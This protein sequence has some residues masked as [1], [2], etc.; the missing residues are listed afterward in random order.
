[1][2]KT[3]LLLPAGN[4]EAFYAAV[5][6]GADAIYLGI[7]KFNARGRAGNFTHPQLVSIMEIA[8]KKKI[9]I[10]V[11][12]NTVIKNEELTELYSTLNILNAAQ[13]DALIVQ[14][15]GV[16]FLAKKYFPQ[17]RLHCST[18][19]GLHNSVGVN[20]AYK[21]GAVRAVLARELTLRELRSI[22]KNTQADLEVF[23][24]GALCYSFSGMCLFSSYLGGSGANR[25]LCTQPC[26]RIFKDNKEERLLFS[27]KDNEQIELVPELAKMGINSIKIE[28][29]MKAAEY[30][31]RVGKAYRKALDDAAQI[32]IAKRALQFDFA[33][34]KTAYFLGGSGR[35][36]FTTTANTGRLIGRIGDVTGESFIIK[37]DEELALGYRLRVVSA[38]GEQENLKISAI[39]KTAKGYQISAHGKIVRHHDEVYLAG[40]PEKKFVSRLPERKAPFEKRPPMRPFKSHDKPLRR[41]EL[42]LRIDSMAW[43]RKIR[44]E[45]FDR[46]ILALTKKEWA[47]FNYDAPFLQKNRPKFIFELPKFIPEGNIHEYLKLLQDASDKGFTQFSLSHLLQK[48]LLPKDARF[49]TNENV[50]AFNDA[51]ITFIKQDGA[52]NFSYPLESD[53][54]NLMNIHFKSGILPLY[55]TPPVFV[56]RMPINLKDT[57]FTDDRNR[58]FKR[59]IRDGVTYIYPDLPTAW[60]HYREKFEKA[61][62]RSFLIDFSGIAPSKHLPKRVLQHYNE[63]LAMSTATTFNMKMGLK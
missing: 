42:Y 40:I 44:V 17:L 4:V 33:R 27:L 15:W 56:S 55:F 52:Q 49:I 3:E 9:K 10:F 25:G 47:E 50:Y 37:T 43:L 59:E 26:R 45:E 14:D 62:F 39:E 12:L 36:A 13:V 63:S 19:M 60:F 38:K 22:R 53:F 34:A 8:H 46:I 58:K 41:S 21:K 54:D 6:A 1:M 35:Q 5:E 20:H 11:T 51:A 23:V 57:D 2:K 48:D 32:P 29:R 18:Q 61:G 24:H 16:F 30:V 31:F 28:G 7:K